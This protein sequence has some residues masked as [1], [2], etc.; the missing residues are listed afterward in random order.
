MA[1]RRN[2]GRTEYYRLSGARSATGQGSAGDRPF[3]VRHASLLVGPE[4][5]FTDRETA[6]ALE[7]GFVP[8]TLGP[9]V[10]RVETAAFFGL[11][12]MRYALD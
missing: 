1:A 4:G 8:V 3:P 11:A 9:I 6:M 2:S 12:A 5:D 7:A 10:L